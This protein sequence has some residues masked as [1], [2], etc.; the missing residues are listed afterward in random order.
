MVKTKT[1]RAKTKD[2]KAKKSKKASKK[3]AQEVPKLSL[4]EQLA[5]KRK[6]A[7]VR[8]AF[9]QYTS[10]VMAIAIFVGAIASLALE[11]KLGIVAGGGIAC[12]AMCF[13]YPRQAIYAF[14]IYVPFGGTVVYALGGSSLLQLAKDAF[15]IPALIGVFLFC[16]KNKQD[17]ILPKAIKIPLVILLTVMMATMLFVNLPQHLA[18]SGDEKPIFIG[19][20]GIKAIIGYLFLIP[21]IYY[22]IRTKEDIYLV[23]RMQ[24]ILIIICCALAFVQYMMLKTGRCQGTVATGA[25]LFKASLDSRCLV[26]G[27]LLYSPD[28]GQIRLP[29]TFVAPWQWGWFLIS[30]AFFTFGTAFND[31]NFIWRVLGLVAMSMV[32]VNAVIS[33]QRIALALVPFCVVM[34]LVLTGQIANLKRFLPAGIG[35]AL[36]L[37][38]IAGRNP[39]LLN[40]RIDSFRSR[41]EAAPP[42]AFITH[43]LDWA[44]GAAGGIFWSGAGRATNAARIFGKT[45]LVE[46]YHSKLLYEFG[47]LGLFSV[48][49]LFTVLTFAT[50]KAYRE[51]KEPNLR[52]Y[53]ASMWV[54]VFFISYFPYY[55]P[56]DVDPVNVYYWLAAGIALKLPD[57]DRQERMQQSLEGASAPKLTKKE[58]KKLKE[59]QGAAQF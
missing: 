43:Q 3:A 10:A 57:I 38:F 18:T 55:Y 35:L 30:S 50:F 8:Q 9:I 59:S 20:I 29:G 13:K 16:R 1:Q 45:A 6:A 51:V 48:L 26:G 2:T 11:P 22:L 39:E 7:K 28:Q 54:F 52:G 21:C 31:R 4:K 5:L 19:I 25:E 46:T 41:W 17:F 24:V 58:M 36:I 42:Y 33:G 15:F 47:F 34:L 37:V 14:I 32:A 53:A 27:A 40:E 44:A 49:F 56:L 23:L 12:L